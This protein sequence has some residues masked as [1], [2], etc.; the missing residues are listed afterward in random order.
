MPAMQLR[1]DPEAQCNRNSQVL[2]AMQKPILERAA[3]GEVT[4]NTQKENEDYE[5]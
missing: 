1:M 4:H 2:P 5:K 3:G